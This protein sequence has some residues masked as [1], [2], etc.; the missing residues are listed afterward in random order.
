LF[1]LFVLVVLLD[2]DNFYT[3]RAFAVPA[4]MGNL[5]VADLVAPDIAI[6]HRPRRDHKSSATYP[7]CSTAYPV[8]PRIMK[9]LGQDSCTIKFA[10][11]PLAADI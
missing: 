6:K 9:I 1:A 10:P 8:P 11:V 5:A 7:T 3:M 2:Y 4:G